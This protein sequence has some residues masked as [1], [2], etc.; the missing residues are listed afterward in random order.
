MAMRL[1]LKSQWKY[2]KQLE[3]QKMNVL[4]DYKLK[5]EYPKQP[6]KSIYSTLANR[7]ASRRTNTITNNLSAVYEVATK[8]VG[9]K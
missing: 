6:R 9:G 7:R 1:Y 4:Q 3:R 5:Y 2:L 8:S